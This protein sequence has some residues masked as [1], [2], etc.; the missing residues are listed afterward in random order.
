MSEISCR[1]VS[2]ISADVNWIL[3]ETAV[4]AEKKLPEKIIVSTLSKSTG[5]KCVLKSILFKPRVVICQFNIQLIVEEGLKNNLQNITQM[6]NLQISQKSAH[7]L[8]PLIY[9]W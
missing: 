4:T 3:I 6:Q 5:V 7:I 9:S 1:F 2:W 8:H